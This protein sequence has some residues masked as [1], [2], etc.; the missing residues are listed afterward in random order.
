MVI[1][2]TSKKTLKRYKVEKAKDL[3]P[4]SDIQVKKKSDF[5]YTEG[6]TIFY[7]TDSLLMDT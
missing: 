2:S 1:L 7:L 4:T 6:C 5:L 3:P